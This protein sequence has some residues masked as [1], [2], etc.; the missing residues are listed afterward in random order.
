MSGKRNRMLM[1][2]GITAVILVAATVW[3]QPAVATPTVTVYK[4]PT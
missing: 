4:T 2:G 3:L 1:G